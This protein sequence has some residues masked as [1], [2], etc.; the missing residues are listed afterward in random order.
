MASTLD[1]LFKEFGKPALE[2]LAGQTVTRWPKGREVDAESV[3]AVF[4][5][6]DPS[7]SRAIRQRAERD[8]GHNNVRRG[9]LHLDAD[10]TVSGDDLWKVDGTVWRAVSTGRVEGGMRSVE[11]ELRT[12]IRR[13]AMP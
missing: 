3:T 8:L 2:S 9:W 4:E 13:R 7:D 11:L 6:E 10:Q 5:E 12:S 1:D